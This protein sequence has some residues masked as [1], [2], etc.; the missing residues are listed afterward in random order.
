MLRS[1]ALISAVNTSRL[2]APL[3]K[4]DSHS[5]Q[6]LIHAAL[7]HP[8]SWICMLPRRYSWTPP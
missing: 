4:A 2:G 1:G 3:A 6:P 7:L 8:G 5:I